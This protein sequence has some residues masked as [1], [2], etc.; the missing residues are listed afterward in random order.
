MRWECF[1]KPRQFR[2]ATVRE[3]LSRTRSVASP[4]KIGCTPGAVP[5]MM[6]WVGIGTRTDSVCVVDTFPKYVQI[7]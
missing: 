5:Q 2:D 4:P 1:L 3:R 7:C 6:D